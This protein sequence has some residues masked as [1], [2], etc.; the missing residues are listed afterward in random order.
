ML[1]IFCMLARFVKP[2]GS[3][4][5]NDY[6]SCIQKQVSKMV[7]SVRGSPSSFY[8]LLLSVVIIRQK[9]GD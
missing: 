2:R 4:D 9:G 8:E 7:H 1:F 6:A 3:V 5:P